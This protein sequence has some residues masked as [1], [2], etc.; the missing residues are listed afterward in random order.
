MKI[1]I[2]ITKDVLRKSMYCGTDK[3]ISSRNSSCAFALAIRDIF[4]N[5]SV[6]Y[7][8]IHPFGRHNASEIRIKHY[9]AAYLEVFDSMDSTPKIRLDLPELEFEIDLPQSVIDAINI[10][11]IVKSETLELV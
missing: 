1:K 5:A 3:T 11:D 2:K 9:Q 4:P 6:D 8:F 7:S 10:D